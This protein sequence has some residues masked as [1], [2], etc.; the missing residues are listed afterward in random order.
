M[1]QQVQAAVQAQQKI[2]EPSSIKGSILQR[3]AVIPAITPVHHGMLQRCSNG[4]ECGECRQR[5]L[6]MLQR[7]AVNAAPVNESANGVPPIVHE[8]LSSSGQ[9]LDAGTRAFMEPRFGYDFSGVRVHTDARA[10]ESAHAVNALAYTVGQNMVFGQGQYSTATSSGRRLLAHEL[11]HTVQQ[12]QA[13]LS[14]LAG[15]M[16]VSE[17]GDADEREAEAVAESL[18]STNTNETVIANIHPV[19]STIQRLGDLTKVPPGLEL[20]CEIASDSPPTPAENLLFGNGVFTLSSLQRAQIDNFVM[21]W[22]AA[23]SNAPV[24]VDGYASTLGTDE[25]NWRLSCHRVEEVVKELTIPSSGIL[26]IPA[27]FI[28]RV[29]QGET[30]EFGAEAKNRR[31]TISSPITLPPTP[32]P[33][34]SPL[35]PA[36]PA[37]GTEGCQPWQKSMLVDHLNDARRWMDDAEPKVRAFSAGTASPA[38]AGVVRTALTD[39]FHTT[40]SADV[41]TI[42]AN[43]TSLRT[44]LNGSFTYECPSSWWCEH[45][46]KIDL[47]YVR[48]S[49]AWVRRMF[50][51][52]VCPRW[53]NC[54]DYFKRVSTLI[55]ERAH[56]HPGANDHAYEWQSSYSSLSSSDAIDNADSYAVAARQIFH[57]GAE[58][59]GT[60]SCLSASPSAPTPGPSPVPVPTPPPPTPTP[61]P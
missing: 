59:P 22:R 5:R 9:A 60:H 10:A 21:N 26:G 57:G 4:V 40:S 41:A 55:H 30:T 14:S 33:S 37:P 45:D 6:G 13:G 36:P 49:Y 24:R 43:F 61:S 2:A 32:T 7:S 44:A 1:S 39:N 54:P 46:G 38:I 19:T 12:S 27:G 29:A 8:V 50:D 48:G 34:P 42:T 16:R 15:S 23:G 20:E 11:T 31:A 53:F 18:I 51:I 17:S 28:R 47:A 56:Q 25:F 52:N 3:A 58:G 35:P